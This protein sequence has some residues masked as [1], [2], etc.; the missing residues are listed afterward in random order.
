MWSRVFGTQGRYR[1]HQ[2]GSNHIS[3]CGTSMGEISA[4]MF[5]RVLRR[6]RRDVSR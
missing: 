3:S 5:L 6:W 1:G 4:T 2:N